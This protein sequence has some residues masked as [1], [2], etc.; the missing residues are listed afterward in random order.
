MHKSKE[1][2]TIDVGKRARKQLMAE[3]NA[4]KVVVHNSL[5]WKNLNSIRGNKIRGRAA[6]LL[7][8]EHKLIIENN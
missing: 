1:L 5:H 2:K 3:F 4:S 6:E 8:E 7:L